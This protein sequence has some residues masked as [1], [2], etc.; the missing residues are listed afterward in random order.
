MVVLIS[1]NFVILIRYVER[2]AVFC[3]LDC[4]PPEGKETAGFCYA[5]SIYCHD[6]HNVEMLYSKRNFR[7]YITNICVDTIDLAEIIGRNSRP[8]HMSTTSAHA[9]YSGLSF[10]RGVYY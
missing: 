1:I 4:T 6:D 7:Y 10:L 5:C 3:C 2:Q 8:A 9:S